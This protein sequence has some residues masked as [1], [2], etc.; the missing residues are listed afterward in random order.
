LRAGHPAA[1]RGSSVCKETLF[2][3][4]VLDNRLDDDVGSG[5]RGANWGS[6][7]SRSWT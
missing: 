7:R 1:P 5:D 6:A 3:R 4:K 2:D